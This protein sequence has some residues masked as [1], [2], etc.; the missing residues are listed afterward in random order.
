[1]TKEE[2]KKLLMWIALCL[3]S[4]ILFGLGVMFYYKGYGTNGRIRKDLIPI[5]E[6][7]NKLGNIKAMGSKINAE[8]KEQKIIINYVTD[9]LDLD[10][11]FTY[12]EKSG[13]KILKTTFN[14]TDDKASLI[15]NNMIDAISIKN[16]NREKEMFE[17]YKFANFYQTR[18]SEHGIEAQKINGI[19]EVQI[20][21][22]EKN[23]LSLVQYLVQCLTQF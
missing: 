14:E 3:G 13:L 1:M 20:S 16:G 23:E 2:Q 12:E 21:W 6:I 19:I 5:V 15:V 8:Y 9:S 22:E 11:V 10:Y 18:I 7:Y 4:F 17:K